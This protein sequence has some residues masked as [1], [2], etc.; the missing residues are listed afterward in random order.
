MPS[1]VLILGGTNDARRIAKVRLALGDDV[2]TSL[3]GVTRN[4]IFPLG[5][6]RVGGFG[7]AEG[8]RKYLIAEEIDVLIDATH[9]YAAMISANA[10]K[11]TEGIETKLEVFERAAWVIDPNWLEVSDTSEAASLI[12]SHSKVFVT[13]GR[14]GLL[15]FLKRTD[16]SGIIRSIESP[17]EKIHSQWRLVLQ[18]PPFLLD[19]EISLMNSAGI[20]HL[21]TKNSGGENTLPKLVAAKQLN[22]QVLVIRRP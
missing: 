16:L 7:G 3:A 1:K 12:P 14:R 17:D 22:I 15:P 5:K 13:V 19:D 11:A 21:I 2:T 8:L 20:T 4:P 6:V 18:R 10:R 9:P